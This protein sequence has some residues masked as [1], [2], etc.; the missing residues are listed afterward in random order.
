MTTSLERSTIRHVAP[1]VHRRRPRRSIAGPTTSYAVLA[2]GAIAVLIPLY[3]IVA[4]S[5]QPQNAPVTGLSWP[6]DPQWGNYVEAWTTGSFDVLTRNSLMVSLAVVLLASTFSI[7]AGYAFAT[8]SFPF[9]NVIFAV[10]LIGIALPFEGTILPLYYTLRMLGLTDTPWG[11]ILPEVGLYV[12]FGTFWMRT[13]FTTVPAA[14]IEAGRVDGA[15]PFQILRRLLVPLSWPSITTLFVL[16]F[17]WSWNEFLVA[18]VILQDPDQRTA[19]AGLGYFVGEYT[20]NVPLLAAGS[21]IVA[22]P[23]IVI[24]VILQRYIIRGLTQG[25]VKE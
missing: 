3:S 8:M 9:K 17:V 22:A 25:A 1:Q 5:L 23:I 7:L 11:V 20:T 12:S 18:L 15:T 19:P 21:V 6:T 2:A 16:F 24:Y 10:L 13:A 14:V 4:V